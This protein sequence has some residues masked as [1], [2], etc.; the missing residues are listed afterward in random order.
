MLY[1]ASGF[2]KSFAC[3]LQTLKKIYFYFYWSFAF[4]RAGTN[5]E[6]SPENFRLEQINLTSDLEDGQVLVRTLY[7]S[8]DP[9]M[10]TTQGINKHY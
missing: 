4:P 6:P 8:V 7:L 5:G 9:Y 3:M 10:V 2:I 1:R